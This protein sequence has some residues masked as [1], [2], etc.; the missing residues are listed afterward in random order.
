MNNDYE[1]YFINIASKEELKE[2]IS[3]TKELNLIISSYGEFFYKDKVGILPK[4]MQK[5]FKE[6]EEILLEIEDCDKKI[7]LLKKELK[8]RGI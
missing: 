4:V 6:R 2:I 7:K 8:N 5:I 1:N 3:I